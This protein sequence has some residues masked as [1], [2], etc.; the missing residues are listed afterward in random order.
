MTNM[1]RLSKT[2][3]E[4]GD[5][6]WNFY[7]GCRHK[8]QGV[9][10][11]L[12]PCWAEEITQRFKAHYPNGFEPTF[13]PEVFLSPLRVKKPSRILVNFMGDMFGGW[14]RPS[15]MVAHAKSPYGKDIRQKTFETIEACPQHTFIFLT[16]N[17]RGMIPW[18]P[19]PD[20]C[21]VGFT[22]VNSRMFVNGMNDSYFV[23]ARVK[24][25]SFEPLL[26]W[27]IEPDILEADF[28]AQHLN[29]VAIGGLTGR[30]DQID[31]LAG[32]YPRLTPYKMS[33]KGNRW[34][35]LPPI[36]WVENIVKACDTVGTKVVLKEN[37]RP[38]IGFTPEN[39]FL[40]QSI[41]GVPTGMSLR[42]ELPDV[43]H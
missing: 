3:I 6:A 31:R 28:W 7:S 14:N 22:A 43:S 34:A 42:Q 21:E 41:P 15:I 9:C 24:W 12:V 11:P 8:Q 39:S 26:E 38:L 2:G 40:F 13:Y 16:K 29:W 37:L 27:H 20:N 18:S 32:I 17:P 4:Y 10:P 33:G 30:K 19:F 1:P 5:Y 36:E 23:E 35:L 25:V